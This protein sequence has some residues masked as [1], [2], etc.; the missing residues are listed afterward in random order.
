MRSKGT[1]VVGGWVER[2]DDGGGG[3]W[4]GGVQAGERRGETEKPLGEVGRGYCRW[5]QGRAV[6]G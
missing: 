6:C 1:T 3:G 4:L 2:A 5:D